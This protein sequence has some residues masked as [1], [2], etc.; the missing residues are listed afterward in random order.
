MRLA[1][2]ILAL[3]LLFLVGASVLDERR[4]AW[5]AL[6]YFDVETSATVANKWSWRAVDRQRETIWIAKDGRKDVWTATFDEP[7][8][9]IGLSLDTSFYRSFGANVFRARLIGPSGEVRTI[10]RSKHTDIFSC[11]HQFRMDAPQLTK[12][13]E[14][15]VP[16]IGREVGADWAL[17]DVRFLVE[18]TGELPEWAGKP[19]LADALREAALP[20]ALG[21]VWLL[22][23][24]W[25]SKRCVSAIG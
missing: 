19:S 9:L 15:E 3:A 22:F 20:F 8:E 23:L 11:W 10:S 4:T 25:R 5:G 2:A 24:A 21:A 13:V 17:R 18:G 7:V 12:S 6:P 16:H 14:L 1:V